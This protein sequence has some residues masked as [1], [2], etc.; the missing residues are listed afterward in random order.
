MI[1]PEEAEQGKA[2]HARVKILISL[3]SQFG[4]RL[5]DGN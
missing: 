3:V 4:G 5:K 2:A 1:I